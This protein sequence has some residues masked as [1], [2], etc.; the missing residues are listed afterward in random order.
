MLPDPECGLDHVPNVSRQFTIN[1][2]MKNS[3]GFDGKP[4]ALIV[5]KFER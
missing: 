4:S 5:K 3:F 1:V 2:A